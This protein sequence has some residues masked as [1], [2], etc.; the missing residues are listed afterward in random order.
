MWYENFANVLQLAHWLADEGRLE[1]VAE[2]LY[3][4]SKPWKWSDE[5]AEMT[6]A[7]TT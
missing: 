7:A 6:T 1:T 2:T 3:Y 4:F 5:W